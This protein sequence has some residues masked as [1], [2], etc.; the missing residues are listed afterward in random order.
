MTANAILLQVDEDYFAKPLADRLAYLDGQLAKIFADGEQYTQPRDLQPFPILG[1]PGWD[2][3]NAHQ[4]YYD[5][6]YYFR[7][8]RRTNNS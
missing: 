1:M 2:A 3:E 6:T 8:G 7:P 4:A 5:N